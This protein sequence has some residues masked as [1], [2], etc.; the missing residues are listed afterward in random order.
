MIHRIYESNIRRQHNTLSVSKTIGQSSIIKMIHPMLIW[1]KKTN[2]K[3]IVVKKWNVVKIE[4]VTKKEL[5]YQ[6]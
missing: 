3:W 4:T 5:K 2:N 1:K 6:K